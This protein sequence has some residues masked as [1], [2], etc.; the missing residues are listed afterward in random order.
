MVRQQKDV[1]I[2]AIR[3]MMSWTHCPGHWVEAICA[4]RLVLIRGDRRIEPGVAHSMTCMVRFIPCIRNLTLHSGAPPMNRRGR[5][6][7]GPAGPSR[8]GPCCPKYTLCTLYNTLYNTLFKTNRKPLGAVVGTGIGWES[9]QPF[10]TR[11]TRISRGILGDPHGGI[12]PQRGN[13]A[14]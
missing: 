5:V 14:Y 12:I 4:S 7:G 13:R 11:S 2:L 8:E 9:G 6:L 1:A 3:F 10:Q